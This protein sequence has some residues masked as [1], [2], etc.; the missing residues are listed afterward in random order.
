MQS[1]HNRWILTCKQASRSPSITLI[2]FPYAGG[3]PE[4]FRSWAAGLHDNVEVIA[5]RL[6]GRGPRIK[7][8]VYASWGPLLTDIIGVLS[9]YLERPH[10]LYGHSFGGRL[11]YEVAHHAGAEHPGRTRRLF[12]S[13]CRSPEA[14]QARP[15]M[16]DLPDDVFRDV[17]LHMGG[18]PPELLN[19]DRLMRLLLPAI[20]S[21]IRLAEL[22]GDRHGTGVDV[23][24]T[25][26]YGRADPIDDELSMDG[27]RGF[28]RRA[29]ELIEMAGG[30]F[31]PLTHRPQLLDTLNSRLGASGAPA[32]L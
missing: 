1:D 24:I 3:S 5:A 23:P 15:Y 28:S 2:C 12:V 29:F 17:L 18:T 19:D 22:W 16:H 10:A 32:E 11:A 9:P 6:P 8:A 20:R 21:E 4:V 31:F 14:P 30:H 13:G 25:A 7:E 26:M 27:W